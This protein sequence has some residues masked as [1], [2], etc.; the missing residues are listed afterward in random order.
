MVKGKP[1]CIPGQA[2]VVFS[3]LYERFGLPVLEAMLA[4]TLVLTTRCGSIPEVGGDFVQY[5]EENTDAAWEEAL[6]KCLQKDSSS[7]K[8]DPEQVQNW[9]RKF[10]WQQSAE[11]TLACLQTVVQG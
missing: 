4:G 10:S 1:R 9:I 7:E 2:Y 5:V 11:Q 3:S 8:P 6:L